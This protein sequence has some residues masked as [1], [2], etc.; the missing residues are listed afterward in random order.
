MNQY[1]KGVAL[2]FLSAFGFALLPILALFVYR[3]G[4]NV[5][6]VLVLR[7]T[8]AFIFLFAYLGLK[9][10]KIEVSR[11]QLALLFILGGV[12]YALQSTFYFSAVQHIPAALAAL[13]L[14]TFPIFVALLSAIVDKERLTRNN[15]LAIALSTTGLALV[16]GA[17]PAVVS[18]LG[19]I[20]ALGAAIVYSIYIVIGNRVVKNLSPVMTS[21]FVALFAAI[22]LTTTGVAAGTLNFA[23][24]GT[25]WLFTFGLVAFSTIMAI[26]CFFRG[27][28]LISPTKA[29]ILSTVEPLITFA[30]SAALLGER[31][32]LI[33]LLGGIAVLAGTIL[34]IRTQEKKT[35]TK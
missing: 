4:V 33:Q 28:E 13:L 29:S 10:T 12:L 3:E 2:V 21:A 1:Y 26:L 14:Y 17:S 25:A 18:P 22:S 19:I 30:L 24:S 11:R 16:L 34:V 32:T 23:L 6:T 20:L 27:L 7:F 9:G 15:L 31:L 8:L 35:E 5:S